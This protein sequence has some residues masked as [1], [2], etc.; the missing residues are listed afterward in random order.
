VS[1]AAGAAA[2]P[3]EVL[4]FWRTAGP[5]RWFSKDAAFDAEVTKRFRSAWEAAAAGRLA[6]W[7]E[8]PEGALGLVILLD[9][10]PRNMFRNDPRAYQ[11]D[12]R[13]RAVAERA[14]ARRFDQRVAVP[15]RRFFY[16][17]FMHSES[18]ADQERCLALALAYGD[19]ELTRHAQEHAE[20]VQRFGRFPHRNAILG[21]DT[22][23]E[24]Q[25]F[26]DGGGF[27][28]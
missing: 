9:Q 3:D 21:R 18:V 1:G 6:D 25:A 2:G 26:L 11:E 13:A 17:P 20:I 22:T 19:D 8:T 14:L 27:A 5:L 7:E 24:E 10:L 4:A 23:A 12:A 28:G 15:D 16:L